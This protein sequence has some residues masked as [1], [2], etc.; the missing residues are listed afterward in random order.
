[1]KVI[2]GA[3]LMKVISGA[4][5]MKVISGAYGRLKKKYIGESDY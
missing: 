5:P 2:S 3:Y 4:Y 1:M